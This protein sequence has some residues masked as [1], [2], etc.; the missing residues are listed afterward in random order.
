MCQY[1]AYFARG[2]F[3]PAPLTGDAWRMYPEQQARAREDR[4]EA[5]APGGFREPVRRSEAGGP[6][7]MDGDGFRRQ[8]D[9]P[10][11]AGLA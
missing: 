3:P 11:P 9:P 10:C 4:A 5:T 8:L 2:I 6:D 7:A 1:R